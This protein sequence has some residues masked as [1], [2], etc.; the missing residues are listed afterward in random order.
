MAIHPGFV[1]HGIFIE[2]TASES[3][4]HYSN[5]PTDNPPNGGWPRALAGF[6]SA[7]HDMAISS[8]WLQLFSRDGDRD[9]DGSG[10]TR[11]LVEALKQANI[12]PVGWGYCHNANS[13]TDGALAA[14]LCGR[15][16]VTAFVADIEP[17][18]VFHGVADKWQQKAFVDFAEGLRV[19]F[20]KDNLALSTFSRLDKHPDLRALVPLVADKIS[21]FAPQIYWTFSD[22]VTFTEQALASWQNAGIATSI[23]GTAEC[24]WDRTKP[25]DPET[26]P[27]ADVEASVANFLDKLPTSAWSSMIGLNWYHAGKTY[28]T[29]A[30]GAMSDAMIAKIKAAK[31]NT[32]PFKHA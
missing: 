19:K 23:V 12:V 10:Q 13:G 3:L 17:G 32:K 25:G 15:Y 7:L 6:L 11:E 1:G 5:Y 9:K 24:Y 21:A 22:P 28:P 8:V 20:G 4:G 29:A 18:N 2:G 14:N 27:Q 26:P 30:E 16:G 31:I